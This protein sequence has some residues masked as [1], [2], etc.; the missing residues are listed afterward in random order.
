M[1]I[2]PII[3]VPIPGKPISDNDRPTSVVATSGAAAA[4]E[5]IPKSDIKKPVP[6]T[7]AVAAMLITDK[8][9]LSACVSLPIASFFNMTER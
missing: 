1:N 9:L 3:T 2:I 4:V 5:I 8:T 7:N 6:N